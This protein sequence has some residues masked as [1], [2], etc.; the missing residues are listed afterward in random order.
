[1]ERQPFIASW[2]FAAGFLSMLAA[3]ALLVVVLSR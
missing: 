3:L 2:Q 1:M